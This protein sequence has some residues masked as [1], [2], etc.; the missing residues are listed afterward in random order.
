MT[1]AL[2][3]YIC[4]LTN[5]LLAITKEMSTHKHHVSEIFFVLYLM[6]ASGG[7]MSSH[8]MRKL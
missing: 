4:V 3:V 8:L 5:V 7:R 2:R 6:N 1:F